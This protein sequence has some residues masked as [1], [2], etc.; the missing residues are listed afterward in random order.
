MT[1]RGA[2]VIAHNLAEPMPTLSGHL[3][4]ELLLGFRDEL[5]EEI[6]TRLVAI[7]PLVS[8]L[9]AEYVQEEARNACTRGMEL[10]VTALRTGELDERSLEHARR[11]AARRAEDQIP[12]G[13][14]VAAYGI[15]VEVCHA[16]LSS[17]ARP[18][19]LEALLVL[20]R[21]GLRFLRE[22]SV[23][24][25]D[26]Y[27]EVHDHLRD[28]EVTRR[29]GLLD[30]LLAG[31]DP[32]RAA[33]QAG[34]PLSDH[35]FVLA[36]G[37]GLTDGDTA[38][39]PAVARR[40]ARVVRQELARCVRGAVLSRISAAGGIAL[41]PVD[42]VGGAEWRWLTDVIHGVERA[43]RVPITVAAV[44]APPLGVASA[45]GLAAELLELA[46]RLGRGPGL[47]RLEDMALEYQLTRP[48]PAR[49]RLA[50]RLLP[51]ANEP[52][53]L[54]TLRAYLAAGLSRRRA[55]TEL[56]VHPNTV[57]NRLRKV[58][59]LTGLDVG[60]RTD[61]PLISAALIAW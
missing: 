54:D 12:L 56:D 29:H 49:T 50:A 23:A 13:Q 46:G 7:V 19:D 27:A 28:D 39:G 17:F 2:A 35:Y 40:T 55:A 26:G 43:A 24:L 44:P 8:S 15:G 48:T 60:R 59:K 32:V 16:R 22:V 6:L 30:A 3:V 53:L 36:F 31:A 11:G 18:A 34:L 45:A 20:H 58:A 42:S 25:A 38:S 1:G 21:L 51:L 47:H 41:L 37:F 57:D 10:F 33:T 4:D 5:I 61:L 9:P 52:E 14:L